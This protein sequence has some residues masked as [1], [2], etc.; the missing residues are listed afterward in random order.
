VTEKSG[1]LDE[2]EMRAW[3]NFLGASALLER[4]VDRQLKRDAGLTHVQYEVL[5][6]LAAVPAGEMHMHELAAAVW[7]SKSGV[8][9]QVTQLER[10]GLVTRRPC[11]HTERGVHA[12]ITDAGRRKLEQAAPGHVALVREL[13]IDVLTPHEQQVLSDALSKIGRRQ[14]SVS[15]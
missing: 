12:A 1:W 11:E 13:F 7:S 5:V 2:A 8:T 15:S 10:E 4:Q 3:V 6:R 9:Y 14:D